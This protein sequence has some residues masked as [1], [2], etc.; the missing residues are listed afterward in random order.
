MP[1]EQQT[2]V[3]IEEQY[4][5]WKSHRERV[6]A[7]ARLQPQSILIVHVRHI[8]KAHQAR[9]E[10]LRNFHASCDEFPLIGYC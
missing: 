1:V 9:A 4:I 3:A 2:A 5:D 7:A 10:A 8:Q 6:N